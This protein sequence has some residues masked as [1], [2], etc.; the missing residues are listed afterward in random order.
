MIDEAK[1]GKIVESVFIKTPT[2][3]GQSCS[4]EEAC[5]LIQD[6]LDAPNKEEV[7]KAIKLADFE[8]K[9]ARKILAEQSDIRVGLI[10]DYIKRCKGSFSDLNYVLYAEETDIY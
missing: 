9:R 1:E 7:L 2:P 3:L 5:E 4:S 10:D 6:F 8:I